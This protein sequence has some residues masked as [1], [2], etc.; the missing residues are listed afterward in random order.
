MQ[1]TDKQAFGNAIETLGLVYG[2]EIN[3]PLLEVYWDCLCDR[4]TP[5]VLQAIRCW[6]KSEGGQ[7]MP[8]PIDLIR[9]IEGPVEDR[10]LMAWNTAQLAVRQVGLYQSVQFDDPLIA[11]TIKSIGSWPQFCQTPNAALIALEKRFRQ[12]YQQL[13]R[14]GYKSDDEQCLL[15]IHEA[16][17]QRSGYTSP[18]PRHIKTVGKKEPGID[19]TVRNDRT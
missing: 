5:D 6:P 8:K 9:L 19:L 15:G 17:N 18:P 13:A 16:Q 3:K 11:A 4:K 7:F 1:P 12:T 14:D 2:K 10:S